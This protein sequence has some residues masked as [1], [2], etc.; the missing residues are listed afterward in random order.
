MTID[1]NR[2]LPKSIR[3]PTF[4]YAGNAVYFITICTAGG[5]ML[6]GEVRN[7]AMAIN[8]LGWIVWEEWERS[9]EI[10][11]ETELDVFV[12]MPNHFHAL[13]TI[14]PNEP[15]EKPRFG[16]AER[17]LQDALPMAHSRAPLRRKPRSLGSLV[18]GFKSTTTSRINTVRGMAGTPVWQRNYYE[19]NMRNEHARAQI[20]SYN[21]CNP[22]QW[23]LDRE[24]PDRDGENAF[25]SWLFADQSPTKRSP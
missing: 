8:E 14:I 18:A 16:P 24:N 6:F 12:V 10:R 19:R 1:A 2:P 7:G 17:H 21:E 15:T 25:E 4:D 5:E 23:S 11:P 13:V 20:A 22:M 3:L 9:A